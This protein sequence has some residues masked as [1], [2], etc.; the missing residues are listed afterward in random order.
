MSD[1]R[2]QAPNPYEGVL[3]IEAPV[4][5]IIEGKVK[6]RSLT[7][8]EMGL[9]A[10]SGAADFG[11]SMGYYSLIEPYIYRGV[12]VNDIDDFD[13]WE[14]VRDLFYQTYPVELA[15]FCKSFDN[16]PTKF[17]HLHSILVRRDEPLYWM[18]SSDVLV[19]GFLRAGNFG[20]Y[21][22]PPGS[23]KT[24]YSFRTI[25]G[26]ANLWENHLEHRKD[27]KLGASRLTRVWN[28]LNR[29]N[30]NDPF[31]L[32]EEDP[33]ESLGLPQSTPK[34]LVSAKDFRVLLNT[35]FGTNHPY[36][37]YLRLCPSLSSFHIESDQAALDGALNLQIIDEYGAAADRGVQ[38]K[39]KRDLERYARRGRKNYSVILYA[40]QDEGDL[41]PWIS[42]WLN[43]RI[44]FG[45]QGSHEM[46]VTISRTPYAW[47]RI[48]GV[49]GTNMPYPTG[50]RSPVIVDMDENEYA[51]AMGE[52]EAA[53]GFD[54]PEKNER[55]I[56]QASI[57]WVKQHLEREAIWKEDH[58][59]ESRS[60]RGRA[61]HGSPPEIPT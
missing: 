58:P 37:K 33:E 8:W 18:V 47:H 19:S 10:R 57:R 21:T 7:A 29:S 1:Q 13:T 9:L 43:T 2:Q 35:P 12:D 42:D 16:Q 44:E 52:I 6:S 32:P 45:E 51:D 46:T 39:K 25:E 36:A 59:R 41:T 60:R 3:A 22:G 5:R 15:A 54:D 24:N 20:F 34:D 49:W 11:Y 27:P 4:I 17:N 53:I 56:H 61:G 30:V 50:S 55:E 38:N 48:R 26:I 28:S 23:G 31:A 14:I 40:S